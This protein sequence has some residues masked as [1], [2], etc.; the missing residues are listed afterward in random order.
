VSGKQRRL[1]TLQNQALRHVADASKRV[2]TK[3]LDVHMNKLRDQAT[4]GESTAEHKRSHPPLSRH[5]E[6][7]T[8]QYFYSHPNKRPRRNSAIPQS[9]WKKYKERIADI[10]ATPAQR[11]HLS[12]KTVKMRDGLQKAESTLAQLS[13]ADARP[14]H[15]RTFWESNAGCMTDRACHDMPR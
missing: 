10:N 6:S 8:P 3:T 4:L 13:M 5:Q 14:L 9:Q 2:N 12:N 1:G 15:L 7:N 11:S